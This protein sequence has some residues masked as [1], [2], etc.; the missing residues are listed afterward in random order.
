MF[1]EDWEKLRDLIAANELDASERLVE[2]LHHRYQP[3]PLFHARIHFIWGTIAAL[4]QS[5]IKALGQWLVAII[6][7]VPVSLWQ[8]MKD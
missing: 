2:Q 5:Y 6:L 8:K 7:A 4:R 1:N 3:D